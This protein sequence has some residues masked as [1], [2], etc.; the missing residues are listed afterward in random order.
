[1]LRTYTVAHSLYTFQVLLYQF[2]VLGHHIL[3]YIN[4]RLQTT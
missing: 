4:F 1:M 2:I 3:I